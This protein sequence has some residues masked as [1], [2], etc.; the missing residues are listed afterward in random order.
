LNTELA[1]IIPTYNE[2]ENIQA[3]VTCL[4]TAL[5]GI[6]WEIICVDDDSPDGTA[7]L[8]RKLS[9][10]DKR[11]RCVQRIKRRGLSSA[12]IEGILASSAPYIAVMDADMQHDERILP[13]MLAALK[14]QPL[15]IIIGSRYIEGGSTGN[16]SPSRVWVSRVATSLSRLVLSQTITDPMSGFFMLRRSFF[17]KVM[18]QLS[19]R[20]FKILLDILVS[21]GSDVRFNEQ[22]Y[23]MRSRTHGESKL[24]TVVI[25]EYL[26]LL[27][28]K[29]L[30][31]IIPARF[32]SFAAVG[33]SGIFVNI[34]FLWILHRIYAADFVLSQTVA[35]L[36]AMTSNYILNNQFTFSEQKLRG[37]RF[38]YG[39]FSF[40]LS[41][42]MGAIINVAVADMFY[43]KAFPWWLAGLA[44][45]VAGVIWNYAMTSTFTW[46]TQDDNEILK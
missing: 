33:F 18:R 45:T 16:L 35:T 10:S 19:G 9:Q 14:N 11:V 38:F 1:I 37:R 46:R 34:F 24:G 30:G 8:V 36:I 40:Y 32:I 43:L 42:A 31:R 13:G 17:E 41:C 7:E 3:M 6:N 2:R 20:G 39:L 25:W 23:N 27:L 22:P 15:D 26:M 21:A 29:G 12:C 4:E 44:G 5:H 28:Y